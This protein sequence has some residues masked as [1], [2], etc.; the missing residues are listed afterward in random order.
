MAT[1]DWRLR[2]RMGTCGT[3]RRQMQVQHYDVAKPA[4]STLQSKTAPSPTTTASRPTRT[5]SSTPARLET[6]RWFPAERVHLRSAASAA[7]QVPPHRG[8][9]PAGRPRMTDSKRHRDRRTEDWTQLLGP[10]WNHAV[11]A[12]VRDRLS[13]ML[14][15]ILEDVQYRVALRPVLSEQFH[16]RPHVVVGNCRYRFLQIGIR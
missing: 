7:R 15:L 9:Q 6:R 11:G 4:Q 8:T 5:S 1:D 14:V 3:A 2:G 10:R 12:R 13:Q 16:R